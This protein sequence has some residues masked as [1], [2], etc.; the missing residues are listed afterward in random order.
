M[1]NR[2]KD[3]ADLGSGALFGNLCALWK[4]SWRASKRVEPLEPLEPLEPVEPL[5]PLEPLEPVEPLDPVPSSTYPPHLTSRVKQGP[6][7][8]VNLAQKAQMCKR[9]V[10]FRFS[11]A[12]PGTGRQLSWSRLTAEATLRHR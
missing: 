7:R 11:Q 4:M 6:I 2:E 9:S 12:R 3:S 8:S 5:E 10:E 1:Q